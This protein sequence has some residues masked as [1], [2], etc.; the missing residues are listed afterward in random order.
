MSRALT[1]LDRYLGYTRTI[2]QLNSTIAPTRSDTR[3]DETTFGKLTTITPQTFAHYAATI[4]VTTEEA[5]TW[6]PWAMAYI[7]MELEE[8]PHSKHAAN[9]TRTRDTAHAIIDNDPKW[10]ITDIHPESMGN[11]NPTTAKTWAECRT[12]MT[13]NPE[14]HAKEGPSRTSNTQDSYFDTVKEV[15][16]EIANDGLHD[17]VEDSKAM[18]PT[19]Y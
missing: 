9:L 8:R 13:Q 15:D 16:I 14:D 1:K 19:I 3:Y 17:V 10:V 4:G 7:A 11:Y 12:Q 18:G 6:Q 2:T 5:E